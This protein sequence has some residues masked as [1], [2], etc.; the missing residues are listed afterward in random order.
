MF[1][2]SL[3]RQVQEVRRDEGTKESQAEEWE[4]CNQGILPE[5]R[6][7]GLQN[8]RLKELNSKPIPEDPGWYPITFLTVF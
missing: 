7:Q 6:H 1:G 8:R 2:K 3:L 5:V 4:A